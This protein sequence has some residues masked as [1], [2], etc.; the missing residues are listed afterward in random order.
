MFLAIYAATLIIVYINSFKNEFTEEK[1]EKSKP[2][3]IILIVIV[4]LSTIGKIIRG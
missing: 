1:L 4:I 3:V 2:L